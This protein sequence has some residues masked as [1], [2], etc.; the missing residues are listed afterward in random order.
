MGKKARL[1]IKTNKIYKQYAKGYDGRYLFY[2]GG[3]GSGKSIDAI[4]RRI[5]QI[6][7]QGDGKH[8][9]LFIRKVANTIKDSIWAASKDAL[10]N[11]GLLS[12]CKLNKQEKSIVYL[13]NGNQ[14][15]MKGMDDA[16][17]IKSIDGITGILIEEITELSEAEFI[18]LNL[19]LRGITKYPKQIYAMFN[20]VD[21]DHWLWSYV[22]PHLKGESKIPNDVHNLVFLEDNVWQ[23]D[24]II[25]DEDTGEERKLTTR[26][27]NTN[28]K[29]NRF[30]DNDYISTLKLLA[31]ISENDYIVYE[32]GRWGNSQKGNSFVHQ[33]RNT[34]HV[35]RFDTVV[36]D[37]MLPIHYTQDFNVAP[38]MSGLVI[39][40]KYITDDFWAGHA[41]YWEVNIIDELALEHPLNTARDC[42]IELDNRYNLYQGL[43][44]YGDASGN[45]RTGLKETKTLFEDLIKGLP[46]MPE[47]RIP[48]ANPRYKNIAKK[49]LGRVSFL[50]ILF[51]GKFPVRIRISDKCENFIK[52]LK[53]AVQNANGQMDKKVRDGHHLD[54]FTY[55]VCHPDTLGYLARINK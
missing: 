7:S 22:E 5:S 44:L 48:S 11:W 23:F 24:K 27:I 15:I 49:S 40:M 28:Y 41:E 50:N 29:D 35:K 52:D 4:Q 31:S 25:K 21:E 16:E 43:L 46:F 10:S 45:N 37:E 47:K 14:I 32:K 17:K 26:T 3:G 54:A 51:S 39:Q 55:F 38:Y 13:P 53:Y 9:F 6:I 33:F 12:Q 30:I 34:K 36:V 2:F 1:K 18:Q 19:R 42:G 8:K 20:P